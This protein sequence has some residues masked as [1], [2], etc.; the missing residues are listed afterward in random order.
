MGLVEEEM[1]EVYNIKHC[2]WCGKRGF[3]ES[4]SVVEHIKTTHT[5]AV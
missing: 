3:K 5:R 2:I 4:Q 1:N